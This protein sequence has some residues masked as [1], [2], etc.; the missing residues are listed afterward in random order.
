MAELVLE[1]FGPSV[2]RRKDVPG[3][4]SHVHP[5]QPGA[6]AATPPLMLLHGSSGNEHELVPFADDPAPGSPILA[7][8][9]GVPF[10]GGYAFFRRFPDR[11]VIGSPMSH[12][13]GSL[14]S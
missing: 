12:H 7:V 13:G 10:D 1:L 6:D 8:H 4:M 2:E 3:R 14:R 5:L 9:G 11:S